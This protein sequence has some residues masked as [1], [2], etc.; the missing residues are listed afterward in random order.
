M[1]TVLVE[2]QSDHDT[3]FVVAN[4]CAFFLCL[5]SSFV[6]FHNHTTQRLLKCFLSS[7]LLMLLFSG[8]E[9]P[10]FTV[11]N[12]F[13]VFKYIFVV[14]VDLVSE[15]IH[16]TGRLFQE[17]GVPN[18]TN[19]YLSFIYLFLSLPANLFFLRPLNRFNLYII[20]R[21]YNLP[22]QL[23]FYTYYC[24]KFNSPFP[25]VVLLNIHSFFQTGCVISHLYIFYF[26]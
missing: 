26:C 13:I 2:C 18:G 25:A 19:K 23:L 20:L 24:L 5:I 7:Y 16:Y 22:E 6:R 14:R 9:Q 4:G 10:E 11:V 12:I 21:L 8:I 1:Y 15:Q 3:C 17:F